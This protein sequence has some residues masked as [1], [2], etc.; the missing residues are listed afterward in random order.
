MHGRDMVLPEDIQ[1]VGIAVMAHRLGHDVEQAGQ[2][3]RTLA[4]N[5]LH[6][7]PVP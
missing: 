2:S 4:D 5:L 3:G 1:V 6:S 7:V